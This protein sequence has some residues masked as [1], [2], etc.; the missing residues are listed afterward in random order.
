MVCL[1]RESF[2]ITDFVYIIEI[3]TEEECIVNN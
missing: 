3:S 2:G 1:C